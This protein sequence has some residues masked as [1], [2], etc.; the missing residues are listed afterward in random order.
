MKKILIILIAFL[1]I[2]HIVFASF[3]VNTINHTKIFSNECDNLIL[4]N[5]DEISV[6][7]IEITPELI[8]YKKCDKE[9]GPLISVLKEDVFMIKYNDGTKELIES[10]K[11]E[12]KSVSKD[13]SSYI[14]WFIAY[15]M[16]CGLS[17]FFSLALLDW[18]TGL[19]LLIVALPF[20]IIGYTK[21]KQAES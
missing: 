16:L 1:S 2:N 14:G 15:Y 13:N 20:G 12:K 3:P 9:N 17:I 19:L 4:K 18:V 10:S 6:K 21:K 8:K 7:I 5:G 11:K